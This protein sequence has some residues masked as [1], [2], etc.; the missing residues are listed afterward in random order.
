MSIQPSLD[1]SFDYQGSGRDH[2]WLHF[3]R[4]ST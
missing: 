3:T 1:E 4:H 2:L